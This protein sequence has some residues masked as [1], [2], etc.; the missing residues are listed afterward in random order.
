MPGDHGEPGTVIAMSE[1]NT[2]VIRH[3]DKGGDSRDHFKRHS[4]L[5]QAERFFCAAS[6]NIGISPFKRTTALPAWPWR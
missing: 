4:R 3:R 5:G 2:R 6:K 1:G